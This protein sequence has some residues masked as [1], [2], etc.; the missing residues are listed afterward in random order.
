MQTATHLSPPTA[1]RHRQM[2]LTPWQWKLCGFLLLATAL[3]YLD[4]QALSVVAPVVA[5]DLS[6]DNEKLG[7]LLS[8][9]F[10]T[11]AAMHI[12]VGWVLDRY[13]LKYTYGAFV[14]LWSVAQ[15]LAGFARGFG[16]L[17]ACRLLLG[18]FET[19][20][21]TGA[22]RI[23]TE[24]ARLVERLDEAADLLGRRRLAV[25]GAQDLLDLGHRVLAVEERDQVEQRERKHRHLVGEP[26]GIAERDP[27]LAVLLDGKRIEHPEPWLVVHRVI[28]HVAGGVRGD[29]TR[30][31][32]VA[33][34][35]FPVPPAWKKFRAD[36]A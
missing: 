1:R 10:Y 28:T 15:M 6:L 18:A 29:Q 14:A 27:A 32:R 26:R 24:E 30:G 8:A 25:T 3:S 22:A 19:A 21:Q 4:R 36:A 7:R 16:E 17:F 2:E 9:F 5:N 12:G 35:P 31:E 34:P 23:T 33:A 13:N 11:Y 20:G